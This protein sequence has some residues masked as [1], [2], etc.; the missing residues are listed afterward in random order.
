LHQRAVIHADFLS[1]S[2]D[3]HRRVQHENVALGDS[4]PESFSQSNLSAIRAHTVVSLPTSLEKSPDFFLVNVTV[5][6]ARLVLFTQSLKRDHG[7]PL[8][9]PFL[10]PY[11]SRS[12]PSFA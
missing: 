1:V 3:D 6:D 7:P 4:G 11:S 5:N 9:Q 2:A 12:P 10:A 8:Q